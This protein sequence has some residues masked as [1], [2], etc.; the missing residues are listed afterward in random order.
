MPTKNQRTKK[1][2]SAASLAEVADI[3]AVNL[4]SVKRWRSEG[5]PGRPGAYVLHDISQWL[6]SDGPWSAKAKAP[7]PSE[8]PLLSDGDSPGL[9]R[10]RLAKAKHAELDLE[11][12]KG[13][14]IEK[15]KAKAVLS[16]WAWLIRQMGERL[17]KR[18]GNDVAV[19]I[20]DTLAECRRAVQEVVNDE[21]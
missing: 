17:A 19:T 16:R 10:Y 14:L 5:M 1:Q 6:R 18:Y 20:N 15:D 12:R 21:S 9:E 2:R 4:D 7:S 3:Y 11:H 8:D 13:E